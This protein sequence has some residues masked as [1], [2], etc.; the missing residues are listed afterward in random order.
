MA[1]L[2]SFSQ[3]QAIKKISANNQS[4]YDQLAAEVEEFELSKLLGTALLQDLQ[5]HP[6]TAANLL[7]LNGTIY[8]N[9]KG[10]AIKHKGLRHVIA[11]LNYA[12]Y[13]GE[14]FVNDTFSGMVQ[15]K[16]EDSEQLSEG[17][18]RRL[19]D[20]ARKQAF[21]Q[22]DLIKEY[23]DCTSGSYSLW[24]NSDSKQVHTP[25]FKFIQKTKYDKGSE[26]NHFPVHRTQ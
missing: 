24:L 6:T 10:Q 1:L 15:K 26:L 20:D 16:R 4:K 12:K 14:N 11:Y 21:L 9:Y 8:T 13:I 3:Q 2:L 18:I 7:L 22:W 5:D 17:T 19:Q 23:L 25:Q